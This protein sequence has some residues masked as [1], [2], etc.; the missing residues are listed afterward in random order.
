MHVNTRRHALLALVLLV[1]APSIG[2]YTA[3]YGSPGTALGQG[4]FMACKVWLLL[5]PLL[6]HLF[7]DRHRPT[8]PRPTR[9]GMKAAIVSGALIFLAI[10]VGYWLVRDRIDAPTVREKAFAV[11]LSTPAIY[12]LGAIYWCTINSLLEEYVWRWFV[13][14]RCEVLMPRWSAVIA[15]GLFFT[16][17]HVIALAAYFDP[18]ITALAS[19]GV[20]VGGATWSWIYLTSRNLYAAY[21]SHVFAD[22]IIFIIGYRLIFGG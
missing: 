5:L 17:H 13:F 2:V 20:F 8:L 18:F 9:K 12:L 6:W 7:V 19:L 21:V 1:P 4:V 11:G 14:T 16:I 15:S 22:V 3:A 10:A